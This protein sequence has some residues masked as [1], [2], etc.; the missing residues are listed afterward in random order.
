[1]FPLKRINHRLLDDEYAGLVVTCDVDKTYLDTDFHSMKGL[2]RIPL[3]WGEDKHAMIGMTPLLK[4]LRIFEPGLT[5]LYF[6]TAS[7]LFLF[8]ALSRKMLLDGVQYDGITFK[9]WQDLIVR[10]RKPRWLKM[11]LPYKLAALFHQ[12]QH[13]PKRCTEILI[14]DDTEQDALAYSLYARRLSG[15]L[16]DFNLENTLHQEGCPPET[17]AD[18]LSAAKAVGYPGNCVK[19]IYIYLSMGTNPADYKIF[20]PVLTACQSPFQMAIH[21]WISGY[22]D[23]SV[24]L[25]TAQEWKSSVSEPNLQSQF[26]NMQSRG[27]INRQQAEELEHSLHFRK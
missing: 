9:D 23:K 4:G 21:L 18:V 14:G 15:E 13:L 10:R 7:P 2:L 22:L 11:Q 19:Q 16:D 3:E 26:E 24:V 8:K 20:G 5:P 12:R 27:L 17:I 25:E 1:M 6:I